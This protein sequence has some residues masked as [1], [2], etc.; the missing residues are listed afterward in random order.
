M[1]LVKSKYL[2]QTTER[3][4]ELK[5][6]SGFRFKSFWEQARKVA[7]KKGKHFRPLAAFSRQFFYL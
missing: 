7:V 5:E 4:K 2:A 3:I 1:P 6:K